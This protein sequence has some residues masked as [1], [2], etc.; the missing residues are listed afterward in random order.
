MSKTG[1]VLWDF[2]EEQAR[3]K[4]GKDSSWE[5]REA[6]ILD[7][8]IARAVLQRRI[9]DLAVVGRDECLVVYAQGGAANDRP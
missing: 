8:E 2:I 5:L 3:K 7:G 9:G 1:R 4:L 6:E